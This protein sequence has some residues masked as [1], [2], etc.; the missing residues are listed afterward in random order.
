M[1]IMMIKTAS[2]IT[3]PDGAATM[4]YEAG[5]EYEATED[6]QKRVFAGMVI[7]GVANEIGGNAAPAETKKKSVS[8]T[9][10]AN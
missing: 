10:K 7:Q 6:W 9:K 1:K 8:K 2:A 3:R 5:K 4:K